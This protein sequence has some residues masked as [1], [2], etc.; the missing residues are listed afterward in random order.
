[1]KKILG[2]FVLALLFSGFVTAE[3]NLQ[4]DYSVSVYDPLSRPVVDDVYCVGTTLKV[5][6]TNH[7][8]HKPLNNAQVTAYVNGTTMMVNTYAYNGIALVTIKAPGLYRLRIQK[9]TYENVLSGERYNFTFC[10][11]TTTTTT[12]TTSTTTT[13]TTIESVS[14]TLPAASTTSTAPGNAP[15]TTTLP[16]ESCSDGVKNQDEAGID[17]GGSCGPCSQI[18]FTW[19]LIA[20]LLFAIVGVIIYFLVKGGHKGKGAIKAHKGHANHKHHTEHIEAKK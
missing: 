16:A 17:C 20:V 10:T 15:T 7:F 1:M 3:N 19:I 13:T 2:F 11:S 14:T 4:L 18:D 5:N 8:T 9:T 12:T 6:V